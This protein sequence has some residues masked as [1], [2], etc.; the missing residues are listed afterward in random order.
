MRII[1]VPVYWQGQDPGY[2]WA[3]DIK[4]RGRRNEAVTI[5]WVPP[6]EI[7]INDIEF[8]DNPQGSISKPRKAGNTRNWEAIDTVKGNGTLKYVIVGTHTAH[9][10]P[11]TSPDPLIE[12]E[13]EPL[14]PG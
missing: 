4:V 9:G 8:T 2:P 1:E 11:H 13:M 10:G 14:P 3:D 5:R 12:N 7:E 6:T